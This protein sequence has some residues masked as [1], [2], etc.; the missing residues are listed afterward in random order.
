MLYSGC[1]PVR[2]QKNVRYPFDSDLDYDTFSIYVDQQA[3]MNGSV[4]LMDFLASISEV[5]I[6][7]LIV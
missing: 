1:I 5:C 2:F 3:I 4:S 6:S 7:W